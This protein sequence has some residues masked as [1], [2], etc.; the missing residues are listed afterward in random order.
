MKYSCVYSRASMGMDAPVIAV[1]VHLSAGLPAFLMV[2]LANAEVKESR[3]RV[4]SA[5]LNSGFNFPARRITINLAPADLPKAGGRYDLAIA[6]GILVASE[7]LPEIL[8]E[9]QEFVAELGLDGELKA[10]AGVLTAA[11]QTRKAGKAL[12]TAPA[13]GP[14]ASLSGLE[15]VYTAHDLQQLVACLL[16]DKKQ[17]F[18]QQ[19]LPASYLT[20]PRLEQVRGNTHAR[21]ALVLAVA[22]GHN[23]LMVGTPGSGKTLM[24][25]CLMG[26]WPE[27][28]IGAARE[29]AA[30]ESVSPEGFNL[31]GWQQAR[32][33]L[34]HHSCT[35]VAMTGGGKLPTP[36][37]ISLAHHGVLFLDELP[38]FKR[39]VLETLRQP[40]EAGEITISRAN[41][42]ATFPARF[43][44]V[45]AMNPC[46]CGYFTSKKT[47]C[48]C[49][50]A[51]IQAY[52]DK[53]SG[54][55]LDR[56]DIQVMV[57]ETEQNILNQPQQPEQKYEQL[58][59]RIEQLHE[60]QYNRQSCLNHVL[61]ADQIL[62]LRAIDQQARDD[63]EH[64][65]R[66]FNLSL[67][68]QQRL[69]RLAMTICDWDNKPVIDR[70]CIAEAL[71]YRAFDQIH[72]RL[73]NLC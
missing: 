38:E 57:N 8:V 26:L 71:S 6:I 10:V 28:E 32:I 39:S 35:T 64:A 46:P 34:P 16:E 20:Y 43:Q 23:L 56:I 3:E 27:L 15:Q 7:Q 40:M 72:Q 24:A 2:G 17:P 65:I 70:A 61:Q 11:L 5:I 25:H 51:R 33:R 31:E 12:W 29:I 73:A 22:G 36:G 55:L 58:K 18:Q 60:Q 41:W 67:R 45:A 42:K 4:R 47:A 1:E 69:L 21:R 13:S 50:P 44:L 48:R 37:E 54:P 9:D 66:Q 19:Q 49:Q 52:L 62:Q 63:M 59:A 68:S 53:V 30:I 14:E